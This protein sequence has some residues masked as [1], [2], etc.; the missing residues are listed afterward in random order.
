M[1]EHEDEIYPVK[2]DEVSPD[3]VHMSDDLGPGGI[4]E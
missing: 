1:D 4:A 2:D 3:D